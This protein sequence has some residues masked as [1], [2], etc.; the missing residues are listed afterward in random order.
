MDYLG[1]TFILVKFGLVA[2]FAWCS[3]RSLEKLREKHQMRD[4]RDD[5]K[6]TVTEKKKDSA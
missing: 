2:A 4:A 5:Q 6:R 3:M 1:A